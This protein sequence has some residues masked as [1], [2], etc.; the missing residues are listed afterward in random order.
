MPVFSNNLL[1]PSFPI[2]VSS[3]C[4]STSLSPSSLPIDTIMYGSHQKVSIPTDFQLGLLK[5]KTQETEEKEEENEVSVFMPLI[6]SLWG[7]LGFLSLLN[8][9]NDSLLLSF[10]VLETIHSPH[11]AGP[12]DDN[13]PRF[14]HHPLLF[15]EHS[16]NI[17]ITNSFI[18]KP[19]LIY[20]NLREPS[21]S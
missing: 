19:S 13:G 2:H 9:T 20:P 8:W 10:Q 18:N 16:I 5:R 17:F 1:F 11:S 21:V 4:P 6:L 14:L 12:R 15:P 3:I 7:H